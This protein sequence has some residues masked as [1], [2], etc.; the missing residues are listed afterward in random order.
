M[1]IE[2]T[3]GNLDPIGGETEGY[4]TADDVKASFIQTYTDFETLLPDYEGEVTKTYVD[5]QDNLRLS[6]TGGTLTGNLT[7][8]GDPSTNLHAATKQYADLK[9]PLA[10]GTMTGPILLSGSPTHNQH[11]ATKGY[12]D[13][14]LTGRNRVT[15]GDFAVNQ[16]G[17]TSTTTAGL[18][19]I[20]DRWKYDFSAG[21]GSSASYQTATAGELPE[22]APNYARLVS[23]NQNA[24]SGYMA[25]TQL[26]EDVRTLSGKTVT[27][28][29]WAKAG[30]GSPLIAVE[31][32]QNFGSGGSTTVSTYVDR[33]VISQ[34]W[35][36]YDMTVT[37]PSVSGKTIGANSYLAVNLWVSAGTTWNANAGSIG[38][39][40]NTFNIWGVQVEEGLIPTI[41]EQKRYG[42]E[43]LECQRYYR[44][45]VGNG[46]TA[47]NSDNGTSS[48]Q[49]SPEM[50]T[51]PTVTIANLAAFQGQAVIAAYANST[52]ISAQGFV[53]IKPTTASTLPAAYK[54]EYT[55]NAEL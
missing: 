11:P 30:P 15:N 37:L 28:S 19:F 50:R 13:N 21:S 47:V 45:G 20:A 54:F 10:G 49:F 44:I 22:G 26:V 38:I 46:T 18:G 17:F 1:G 41:F 34:S 8:A 55:A 6:K 31:L 35:T 16:R 43:L 36:R 23:A 4:I 3:L 51:K 42:D 39:Q 33:R 5:T 52:G 7:L 14:L 2:Q 53:H 29:F 40:S 32:S 9:L 48:A 25:L 27:V 24:T 12:V